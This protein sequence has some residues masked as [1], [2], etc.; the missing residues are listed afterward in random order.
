MSQQT[1]KQIKEAEVE[2]CLKREVAESVAYNASKRSTKVD[3]WYFGTD[4]GRAITNK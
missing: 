4:V 2:I 3:A 1:A